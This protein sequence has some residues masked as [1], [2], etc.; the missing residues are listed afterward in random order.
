MLSIK[1]LQERMAASDTVQKCF[2]R[3]VM[4]FTGGRDVV[5]SDNAALN[6]LQDQLV[7]P[8]N[9]S[10]SQL[11]RGYVNSVYFKQRLVD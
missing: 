11:I 6:H 10:F 4:K 3:Q 1:D 9:G 8:A 5:A 2:I 7:N